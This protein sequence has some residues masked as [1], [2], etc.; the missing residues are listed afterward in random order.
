MC[1]MDKPEAPPPPPPPPPPPKPIEFGG[2]TGSA[3]KK[4]TNARKS[5][6]I[7]LSMGGVSG[8]SAGLNIP[9]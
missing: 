6:S 1:S 9:T 7:P 8:G 4:S 2:S 3:S 5:L